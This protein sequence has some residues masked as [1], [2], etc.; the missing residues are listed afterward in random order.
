MDHHWFTIE[1]VDE[2]TYALSEYRHWEETHSYLLLGEGENLLIDSGMGIGN[3]RQAVEML[4]QDP[5]TVVATHA[6]WDHIGGHGLFPRFYVHEREAAWLDGAFP[7]P[8]QAV[9]KLVAAEPC[10]LPSDFNLEQYQIFQGRPDRILRDHDRIEIGNRTLEVWHTPGHSPGHMCFY[11]PERRYLYTGDLIYEGRLLAFYPTTDPV[12]YHASVE[13]LSGLDIQKL[14][15]AHHRLDIPVSL[16]EQVRQAF[17]QLKEEGNL[18]H[19]GRVFSFDG[20][21]IQL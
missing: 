1:R 15:P 20:F 9:R 16:L 10:D 12:A 6:H 18:S 13:R 11:E 7:L 5:V 4:T 2:S 3:I 17:A 8:L 21:E 19:Y 14:L